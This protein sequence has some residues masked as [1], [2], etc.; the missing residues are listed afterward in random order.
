MAMIWSSQVLMIVAMFHGVVS[1]DSRELAV[2]YNTTLEPSPCATAGPVPTPAPASPCGTVAPVITTTTTPASPCGTVA[3][4]I[5]TTTTPVSPCGTVAPVITTTTTPASPCGTVAPATTV[6]TTPVAASPCGT[7]AP[8]ATVTTTPAATFT[9]TPAATVT[10]TPA[11]TYTT[12]PAATITTTPAG[13]LAPASPCGTVAPA[14]KFAMEQAGEEKKGQ[15]LIQRMADT[16]ITLGLFGLLLASAVVAM[17]VRASRRS[18][19][20]TFTGRSV[21]VND[22]DEYNGVPAT[23]VEQPFIE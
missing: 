21:T 8:V 17:V 20:L 2:A 6:T 12:T 18:Q 14:A 23:D 22:E 1:E 10:T 3:P 4:V 5:T 9:T 13:T 7:V 19:R 15:T 11:A 16:P